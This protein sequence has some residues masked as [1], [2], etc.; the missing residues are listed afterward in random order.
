DLETLAVTRLTETDNQ[1]EHSAHFSPDGRSVAFL[2][3]RNGIT[4]LYLLDR[5]DGSTV[6]LTNLLVGIRQYSLSGDGGRAAILSLH[7]GTPTIY[8][9]NYPLQRR[10]DEVIL[11]PNVW[12][13]RRDRRPMVSAPSVLLASDPVRR[14]NP[15]L[16]DASDAAGLVVAMVDAD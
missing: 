12:A 13:Q 4:N 3:D 5:D 7:R 16:L 11:V 10:I 6:P 8:V 2:S 14:S 15:F 1:D 9:V